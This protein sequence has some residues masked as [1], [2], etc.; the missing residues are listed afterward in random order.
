MKATILYTHVISHRYDQTLFFQMGQIRGRC[1]RGWKSLVET[2]RGNVVVALL[3]RAPEHVAQRHDLPRRHGHVVGWHL[4]RLPWHN[5]QFK[6]GKNINNNK[7]NSSNQLTSRSRSLSLYLLCFSYNNNNNISY[8]NYN[9]YFLFLSFYAFDFSYRCISVGDIQIWSSLKLIS[10]GK[11]LLISFQIVAR[12]SF[13]GKTG[14]DRFN[15]LCN[16]CWW[17]GQKDNNKNENL[18]E[19]KDW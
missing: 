14:S 2:V 12:L 19:K 4:R 3:V 18:C 15:R 11:S 6:S 16:V 1:W 9:N 5:G 17:K 8:N 7:N 13:I 10:F